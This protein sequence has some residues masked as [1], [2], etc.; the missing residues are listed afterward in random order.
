[1][2]HPKPT[3]DPEISDEPPISDVLTDYD[4]TM[5]VVYLRLL[6][7]DAAGADWREVARIV[8]KIDPEKEPL[9]AKHRHA[10]HLARARWMTETGYR[11]L[12]RETPD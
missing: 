7:A 2:A 3:L 4:H 9:R 1:M 6:D 5:L 11:H 10:T 8:L 12:L